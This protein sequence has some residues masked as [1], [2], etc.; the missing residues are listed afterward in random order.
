MERWFA[1]IRRRAITTFF[2]RFPPRFVVP[3]HYHTNEM[4]VVMMK[5]NMIIGRSG[6]PDVEVSEGGF[7]VLPA[8]MA[9]S[10]RCEQGCTFL[11]HGNN[12]FDIIYSNLTDDPRNAS[13]RGSTSK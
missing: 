11:V 2:G 7:F 12:P 1:A 8:G 9:H 10:A 13:K 5:G 4:M 3:M 6:K